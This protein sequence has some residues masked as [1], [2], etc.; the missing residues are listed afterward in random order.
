MNFTDSSFILQISDSLSR[1]MTSAMMIRAKQSASGGHP[2]SIAALRGSIQNHEWHT[3]KSYNEIYGK[4]RAKE[5][6]EKKKRT[7]KERGI[8]PISKTYIGKNYEEIYGKKR[9]K[10]IREKQRLSSIGKVHPNSILAMKRHNSKIRGKTLEDFYGEKKAF[11]IKKRM[12]GKSSPL[13]IHGFGYYPYD[14]KFNLSLKRAILRRDKYLCSI[15]RKR[16]KDCHHIHYDKFDSREETLVCLCRKHN[17]KVNFNR[18][19][20]FSY[21]SYKLNQEPEAVF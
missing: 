13:Y 15:C 20:W 16:G 17:A 11:D 6:I 19:Y 9:G 18:D 3:G 1:I 12:Y 21:F 14:K 2:N 5:I 10:E 4:K 7:F 8:V